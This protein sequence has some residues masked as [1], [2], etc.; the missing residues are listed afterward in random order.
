MIPWIVATA[1]FALAPALWAAVVVWLVERPFLTHPRWAARCAA[2]SGGASLL[3]GL[4]ALR[5]LAGLL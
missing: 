1:G 3:G 5:H 4:I 2:V